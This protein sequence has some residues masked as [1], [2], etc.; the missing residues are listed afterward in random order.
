VDG[1]VLRFGSR[2]ATYLPQVWKELPDKAEFLTHL[3]E[4]AGLFPAAWKTLDAKVLVY[5]VEAF[6]EKDER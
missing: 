4:K 2:E 3:A 6:E 5:Q 1:V